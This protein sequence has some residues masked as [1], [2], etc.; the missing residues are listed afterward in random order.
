MSGIS[1]GKETVSEH[2]RIVQA[3]VLWTRIAVFNQKELVDSYLDKM[4]GLTKD[5]KIKFYLLRGEYM[6]KWKERGYLI[7]NL[8]L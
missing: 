3:V 6:E 5:E 7:N 4:D 2:F 1:F 8:H